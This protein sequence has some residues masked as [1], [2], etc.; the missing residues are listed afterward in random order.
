M[1]I[2]LSEKSLI[3]VILL[4]CFFFFCSGSVVVFSDEGEDGQGEAGQRHQQVEDDG[5]VGVRIAARDPGE[6]EVETN[7]EEVHHLRKTVF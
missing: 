6:Q 5:K 4:F 3:I 2:R 1:N 7:A